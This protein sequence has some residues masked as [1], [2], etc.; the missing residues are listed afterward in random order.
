[1]GE[2]SKDGV[3]GLMPRGKN[4]ERTKAKREGMREG[5]ERLWKHLVHLIILTKT[6]LECLSDEIKIID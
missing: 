2:E 6:E 3:L 5:M 4:K 1:M